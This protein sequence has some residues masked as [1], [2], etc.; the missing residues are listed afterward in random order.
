MNL[1]GPQPLP[2]PVPK[3]GIR[4]ETL[5]FG[6]VLVAIGFAFLAEQLE[7]VHFGELVK[8]WPLILI[9]VG[10]FGLFR[11]ERRGQVRSAVWLIGVGAWALASVFHTGGLHFGNSWPL[12]IILA[13]VI[14]IALPKP[15]ETWAD[16]LWPLAIGTWLLVS[17]WGWGGLHWGNSWPVLLILIGLLLLLRGTGVLPTRRTKAETERE[18]SR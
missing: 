6:L 8:L 4:Y 3:R 2:P 9:G 11:A 17:V 7:W 18:V 16:G 5:A 13:G 15:K 1:E 10:A 12:L 14:G